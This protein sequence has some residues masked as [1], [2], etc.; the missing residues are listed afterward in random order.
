MLPKRHQHDARIHPR[1]GGR[2]CGVFYHR[3]VVNILAGNRR[4]A[5]RAVKCLDLFSGSGGFALGLERA[6]MK[7]VAFCE[8][9]L[10]A[11][12]VL[13]TLNAVKDGAK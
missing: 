4:Q 13:D 8:N 2:R 6:G 7:T 5:E 1:H 9:E 10:Y 3:R 12:R 11:R